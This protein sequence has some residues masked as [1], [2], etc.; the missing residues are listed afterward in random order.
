MARQSIDK[1][2]TRNR[3]SPRRE[4]YWGAPIERGLFLGFRKLKQGGTWVAR[5][6]D[7]DGR[8]RYSS[9]GYVD[10]MDHGDAVKAARA[11]AKGMRVGVDSS[12]VQTVADACLAYVKNRRREKGDSNADTTEGYFRRTVYSHPIGKVKLTKLRTE[13]IEDWRDGLDM[14]E[15]SRNRTLATL[16]A[17]LNF[18]VRKRYVEASRAIE[19]KSVA[20]YEV[21]TRRDLY[22]DRDQRRALVDNLPEHARPFLR[23]LCLLPLRPGALAACAVA[24]FDNKLGTLR[25]RHDKVHAGRVVALSPTA[26]DLLREQARGKLPKAPLIAYQ[27]GSAWSRFRWRNPIRKSS[28]AADL[29]PETCAYT[30]RHSVIT[31]MLAGG[32]D[33]LTVAKI[34]GTSLAMIEKH[35]GHLLHKH[36]TDAMEK[37]AL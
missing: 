18:A 15:V 32:M 25:I 21:T 23:C 12:E 27:D 24:D 4:P 17:A 19:W 22:L 9:L 3:L 20:A 8:H 10:A 26:A 5:L 37:L 31:D 11:W 2:R 1:A 28:K 7:D 13:H 34:A 33:T 29:P 6:H 35:Y 14:A 30:L 36:A 16:R